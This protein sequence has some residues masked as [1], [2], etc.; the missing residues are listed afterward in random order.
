MDLAATLLAPF[1]Q[2]VR[3]WKWALALIALSVFLSLLGPA[4]QVAFRLPDSLEANLL[5]GLA[6]PLPLNA[7]LVPRFLAC[8]DAELKDDPTNPS[9][10]WRDGFERRWLLACLAKVLLSIFV[11]LGL[12]A[13]VLPGL[14]FLFAFGWTPYRILLRGESL[15]DAA[16]GSFVLSIQNRIGMLAVG[17][18]LGLVY[19]AGALLVLFVLVLA[20]PNPTPL[21]RLV[22]PIFWGSYAVAGLMELGF[23]LAI[24]GLFHHLEARTATISRNNSEAP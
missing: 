8:M 12:S 10:D 20:F 23:S 22:R 2:A 15:R 7:Y 11:V 13:F 17:G 16:R 14:L 21:D 24:L 4:L 6:A 3:H 19:L 9:A 5:L 18:F 1:I